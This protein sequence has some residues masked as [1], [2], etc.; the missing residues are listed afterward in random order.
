MNKVTAPLREVKRARFLV[1]TTLALVVG[2]LVAGAV[3]FTPARADG[4]DFSLNFAAADP[5]SYYHTGVNEGNETVANTLRCGSGTTCASSTTDTSLEPGDFQCGDRVIFFTKVRVG[6]GASGTQSIDIHYSWD[7]EP[8]GQPGVGYSDII[9]VGI[10]NVDAPTGAPF[11]SAQA[12]E[13]GNINL[14]GNEDA[15]LVP[16]SEQFGPSGS[17]FGVDA[18][19]LL[20]IVRVT[21]LNANDE[22][23]VRLDVRFSCYGDDPTGNLHAEIDWAETTGGD[24]ENGQDDQSDD[25]CVNVGQ[26]DVP[27]IGLGTFEPATSTPTRTPTNTPANTATHTPTRT[28]TPTSTPTN[29]GTQ[30]PTNTPTNTGT[31]T[32]TDTPTNTPMHT[33]TNTPTNTATNTPTR[34]SEV[35]P[36]AVTPSQKLKGDVNCDGKVNSRDALMVLQLSAGLK[37]ILPCIKNADVNLDG[38]INALDAFLILQFHAALI[39]HLPPP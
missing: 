20:G 18:E 23:I 39:P 12:S 22:L 34:T 25:S 14:D 10:S 6:S 15:F 1:A 28:R 32:P 36:T 29:T 21:N 38:R 7:A 13:T 33:P 24:C 31:Q 2:A 26:Q 37:N 17:A 35:L 16:G 19:E 30:T 5:A 3:V 11:A 27:M 9:A 4:S 8:T